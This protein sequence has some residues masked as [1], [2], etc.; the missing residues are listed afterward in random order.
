MYGGK[1]LQLLTT[2]TP[3]TAPSL[4]PPLPVVQAL[5]RPEDTST[6]TTGSSDGIALLA[7]AVDLLVRLRDAFSRST[8]LSSGGE[9]ED[10]EEGRVGRLLVAEDARG[11]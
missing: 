1:H 7:D 11:R 3:N 5:R 4:P 6:T 9:G 10:G 8:E 2:T